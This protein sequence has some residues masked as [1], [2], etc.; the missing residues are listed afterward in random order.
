MLCIAYGIDR[1]SPTVEIKAVFLMS[2]P[3]NP[4]RFHGRVYGARHACAH[5]RCKLAGEFRAPNPYG[6]P[7][8]PNGPGDYQWL[9]LDHVREFNAG[10]DWFAGM[11]PEQIL[12]AQSPTNVWP[13]ETRAF[14]SAGNV[15]QPP[16][17]ADFND[18]LEAINARFKG[19]MEDMKPATAPNGQILSGE[20]KAALK[21]LALGND[22]DKRDIRN[23]YSRLVRKYHPDKNGG[24]RRHEKAL[25]DVIA[26]Y[27]HLKATPAFS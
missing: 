13:T 19:R 24:D 3:R 11:T 5:P 27:T 20:D 7:P 10:Y 18:P 1:L 6:R 9:C 25:Q 23:A 16:K 26:A 2:A 22:A 15:D 8:G 4:D 12:A 21:T 14:R 17:W